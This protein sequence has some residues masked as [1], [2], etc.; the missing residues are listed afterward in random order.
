MTLNGS[1][2]SFENSVVYSLHFPCALM[3]FSSPF[4]L[5]IPKIAISTKNGLRQVARLLAL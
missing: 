4:L 2:P 5:K 1:R 3:R